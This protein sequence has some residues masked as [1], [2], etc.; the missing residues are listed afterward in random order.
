MRNQPQVWLGLAIVLVGVVLLFNTLFRIDIWD[1]CWPIGLIALGVLF[2]VRPRT[3]SPNSESSA[4]VIGD[5]RRAEGWQVHTEEF[6]AFIAD[7]KLDLSRAEVPIGET[8]LRY[9]GFIGDI[10][11]KLPDAIGLRVTSNAF[12][13]NV[14][15]LGNNRDGFFLPID[16]TSDNYATAE[17]KIHLDTLC[18]ISDV[19]VKKS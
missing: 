4:I 5:V 1:Y 16:V 17:R 6:W 7:L 13:S 18:F 9:V 15:M 3:L 19:S 14:K 2:L 8:R 11:L 12:I 10:D